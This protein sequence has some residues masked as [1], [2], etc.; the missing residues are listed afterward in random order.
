MLTIRTT[1]LLALL[2]TITTTTQ[3]VDYFKA[4]CT[5]VPA[6]TVSLNSVTPPLVI[7]PA[8]SCLLVGSKVVK[9]TGCGS[10]ADCKVYDP[11]ANVLDSSC[12]TLAVEA[13]CSVA[14]ADQSFAASLT[15]D[16]NTPGTA[17]I[18]EKFV[19]DQLCSGPRKFLFFLLPGINHTCIGSLEKQI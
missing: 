19:D 16:E 3:A 8:N 2:A 1:T 5:A 18:V 12:R 13:P 15:C 4:T 17:V 10:S 9:C 14:S 7:G 11:P 6:G